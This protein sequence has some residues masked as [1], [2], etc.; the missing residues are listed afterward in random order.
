MT[1]YKKHIPK[2]SINFIIKFDEI[3]ELREAINNLEF[4]QI[5]G[6]LVNFLLEK[7]GEVDMFTNP[8]KL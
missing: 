2:N 8:K 4:K 6:D 3:D 7:G 5:Q 1:Y